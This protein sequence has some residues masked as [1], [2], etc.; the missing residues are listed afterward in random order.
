MTAGKQS[1]LFP[2]DGSR[3]AGHAN[4]QAGCQ[5]YH[6]GRANCQAGCKGCHAG[7]EAACHWAVEIVQPTRLPAGS[8]DCLLTC[9]L[10]LW[11]LTHGPP[12]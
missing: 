11:A 5:S 12:T 4:C 9:P 2:G 3:H 6:A 1:K 8:T 10:S 7:H